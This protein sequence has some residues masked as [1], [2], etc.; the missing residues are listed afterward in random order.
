[1]LFI[2]VFYYYYYYYYYYY[3]CCNIQK[4]KKPKEKKILEVVFET[5]LLAYPEKKKELRCFPYTFVVQ[6]MKAN[7]IFILICKFSREYP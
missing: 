6:K 1:M 5:G 7:F 2:V 4:K 3:D